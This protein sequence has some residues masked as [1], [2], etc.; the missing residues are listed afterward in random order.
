V[1]QPISGGIDGLTITDSLGGPDLGLRVRQTSDWQQFKL[2]RG[3]SEPAEL[4][5]SF[6]LNGIGT[7]SIDDVSVAVLSPPTS[8]RLPETASAAL[9]PLSSAADRR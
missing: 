6:T 2:V 5:V 1:A 4:T 3:T 9:V 8:R 7:A